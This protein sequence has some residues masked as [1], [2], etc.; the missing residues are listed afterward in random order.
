MANFTFAPPRTLRDAPIQEAILEF[1]RDWKNDPEND[2]NSPTYKQIADGIGKWPSDVHKRIL[3]MQRRG[4][5][6]VNR[7]G[8]IVLIGGKYLLPE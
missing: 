6:S 5:V 7:H 1:L 8:K 4:L 3:S 2:G